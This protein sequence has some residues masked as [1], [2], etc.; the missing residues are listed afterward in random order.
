MRDALFWSILRDKR[1]RDTISRRYLS[2]IIHLVICSLQKGSETVRLKY[3]FYF[4]GASRLFLIYR[5]LKD[6]LTHVFFSR[7][8]HSRRPFRFVRS[9]RIFLCFETYG[10]TL[11]VSNAFLS[12]QR[13]IEEVTCI[14]L[15]TRFISLNIEYDTS[16]W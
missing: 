8:K 14:Y 6:A 4:L 1:V 7:A 13:T 16:L 12:C 3:F 2:L 15:N 10:S 9:I 5:K 11:V